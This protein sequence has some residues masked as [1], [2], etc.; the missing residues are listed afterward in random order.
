MC[1]TLTCSF[2]PF[3]PTLL[4]GKIC[5]VKSSS[6]I[7]YCIG[8]QWQ[9]GHFG[10]DLA[11]IEPY[12]LSMPSAKWQTLPHN[13]LVGMPTKQASL[14]PAIN[15]SHPAGMAGANRQN[16]NLPHDSDMPRQGLGRARQWLFFPMC[17]LLTIKWRQDS[18]WCDVPPDGRQQVK[19]H[20]ALCNPR[21]IQKHRYQFWLACMCFC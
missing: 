1:K 18:G 3:L 15:E 2:L 14:R 11:A 17:V 6:G 8:R 16:T 20:G 10:R 21:H 7:L 13:S 5:V 19:R 9:A 12:V 4:T